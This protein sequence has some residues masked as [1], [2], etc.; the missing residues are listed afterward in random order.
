MYM[1]LTK[2][3]STTHLVNVKVL[4]VYSVAKLLQTLPQIS[5]GA[6]ATS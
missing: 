5:V 1:Q 4:K 3:S 6:T 2:R